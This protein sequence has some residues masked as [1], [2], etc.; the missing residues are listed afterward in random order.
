MD[1]QITLDREV[2]ELGA[3]IDGQVAAIVTALGHPATG[4]EGSDPADQLAEHREL[5][6]QLGVLRE[7]VAQA[8]AQIGDPRELRAELATLLFFAQTLR[9]DAES[10][11]ARLREE[12]E[13]LARERRAARLRR[14]RLVAEREDA[15]RRRDAL[16]ARIV[17]AAETV[18]R[19]DRTECRRTV[20]VITFGEGLT[21]CSIGVRTPKRRF[22]VRQ[23]WLVTLTDTRDDVLV[24]RT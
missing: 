12:L 10:L 6:R 11:R 2:A 20:P 18:A 1:P 5:V 9:S 22:R 7:R 17:Q 19:G 8:R 16:Q 21:V 15:L 23:F 14:E 13:E 4:S 3:S 24:R